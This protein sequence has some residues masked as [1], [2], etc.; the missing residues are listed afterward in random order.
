MEFLIENRGSYD[1][2]FGY[3][4]HGESR[5]WFSVD[6]ENDEIRVGGSAS[7]YWHGFDAAEKQVALAVLAKRFGEKE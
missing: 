7:G 5:A 1:V 6:R 2:P 4:Y 3:V